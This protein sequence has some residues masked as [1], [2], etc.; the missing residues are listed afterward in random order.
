MCSWDTLI[1]IHFL[2]FLSTHKFSTQHTQHRHTDE[3]HSGA[4]PIYTFFAQKMF[5]ISHISLQIFH[6]DFQLHISITFIY[7]ILQIHM[8]LL[9]FFVFFLFISRMVWMI[10]ISFKVFCSF[11]QSFF[12]Y[13]IPW[14][15]SHDAKLV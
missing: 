6:S 11:M 14:T 12:P 13:E 5:I 9:T 8:M 2:Y 1:Y 15:N 4:W 10:F 3:T 7:L